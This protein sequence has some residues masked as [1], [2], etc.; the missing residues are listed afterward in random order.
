M[1]GWLD[2]ISWE[3]F[4]EWMYYKQIEPFGEERADVRSGVAAAGIASIVAAAA[5][6][7]GGKIKFKPMDFMPQ[8]KPAAASTV[9]VPKKKRITTEAEWRRYMAPTDEIVRKY[10]ERQKQKQRQ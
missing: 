9:V 1:W 8:F 6:V 10:Q 5:G 7:P 2:E 3:Q 4:Q